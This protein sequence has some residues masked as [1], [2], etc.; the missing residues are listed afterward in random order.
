MNEDFDALFEEAIEEAYKTPAEASAYEAGKK[1]V[2]KKVSYDN[3]PNKKGTKEYTAW[4]KG[5]N[6]ARAKMIANRHTKE[7]VELTESP[8]VTFTVPN[9]T[10]DMASKLERL[11]KENDVEYSRK[12]RTVVLKGK[13]IDVTSIRTKMGL[14]QTNISMVPVKEEVELDEARDPSK[15]GGSGY[16]LY[17]KDFSSA[18]KH[19]YD[20]AKKKFGIEIDPKEIDDKVASGPRKPSAGKTNSYRL[21]GKDGKKGVQ[22]Q[23]ANLD[24][25]KYELNM[26]KESVELDEN[27]DPTLQIFGAMLGMGM[28]LPVVAMSLAMLDHQTDGKVSAALEKTVNAVTSKFKKNKNYKPTSAEMNA[29]NKLEKEIKTNNPS[30]FKKAMAKVSQIKSKKESVEMELD[31]AMRV[32]ATKGKTK[33]VTKGDGVALVMVGN[34]EVASGDL[35]DGAGGWFM[36]KKGEKGSK[37]FDSPKKIADYYAEEM[38]VQVDG[39]CLRKVRKDRSSLTHLRKLQTT[40]RRK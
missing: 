16:D 35:D 29:V 4:S 18:M 27:I 19:A 1:A 5:H 10:S 23:V 24:N 15:S 3:N 2:A 22:I 33:V 32:L 8:M 11:A 40:M 31:E 39:S 34:K 28:S 17:H 13:R 36:S 25:K 21:K 38:T 20:Y 6:D 14:A 30:I 12:G 7:E 9:V 37:F 26:Y